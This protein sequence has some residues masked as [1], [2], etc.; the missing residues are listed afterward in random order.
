MNFLHTTII[1]INEKNMSSEASSISLL[2]PVIL[3]TAAVIAVPIFKRIGLGS[4]LGYLVAGLIIGPFGLSFFLRLNINITHC[5]VRHC[6]VFIYYWFKC[7]PPHLWSLR[8]EIFGLGS[9]QIVLC[10]IGL[11]GVGLAFGFNWQ[12]AF[13][14]ASG[15]VLTST[16]IV[17][18]LLGDRGD[19]TQPRGQKIVAI[20]C[21][22]I[23]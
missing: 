8:R 4:V 1:Q 10:I 22:K 2:A 13:I 23:Y 17:M 21:S 20:L 6:H 14:A 16:A 15:F 9:L 7:N 18:Q 12:I 5:R 19:I 11:M 3:L